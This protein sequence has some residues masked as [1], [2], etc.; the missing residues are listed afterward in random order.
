MKSLSPNPAQSDVDIAKFYV[1]LFNDEKLE[2]PRDPQPPGN[3]A[4]A[5]LHSIDGEPAILTPA[6]EASV[7]FNGFA[8]DFWTPT[9]KQ[10]FLLAIASWRSEAR[11]RPPRSGPRAADRRLRPLEVHRARGNAVAVDAGG[12]LS[13]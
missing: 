10:V 5:R 7:E 13:S 2:G 8:P 9:Q 11:K 6:M 1:R 3:S 4:A 12:S